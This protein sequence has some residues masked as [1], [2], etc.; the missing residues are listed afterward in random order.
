[1]EERIKYFFRVLHCL[2]SENKVAEV[3]HKK[4]PVNN[5]ANSWDKALGKR[6][7][8]WSSENNK[9]AINVR[10]I[11]ENENRLEIWIK[12][13]RICSQN[14]AVKIFIICKVAIRY[15]LLNMS[16]TIISGLINDC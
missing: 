4:P 2:F 6:L 1:M 16:V 12:L 14:T 7:K 9:K 15:S 8:L 13:L 3:N 11:T 5:S 10:N